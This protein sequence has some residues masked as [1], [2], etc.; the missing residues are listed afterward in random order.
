MLLLLSRHLE[1]PIKR[2][3]HSEDFTPQISSHKFKNYSSKKIKISSTSNPTKSLQ[4]PIPNPLKTIS[5]PPLSLSTV[6]YCCS[7]KKKKTTIQ[8]CSWRLS[9]SATYWGCS[10]KCERGHGEGEVNKCEKRQMGRL[11]RLRYLWRLTWS[12]GDP[13]KP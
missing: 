3:R 2:H 8:R 11:V 10:D 4:S 9:E 1:L 12:S 6:L 13:T 7:K 5:L